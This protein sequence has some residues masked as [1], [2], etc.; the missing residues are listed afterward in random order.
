VFCGGPLAQLRV[1]LPV[2]AQVQRDIQ[3]AGRL[4]DLGLDGL[5]LLLRDLIE[6]SFMASPSCGSLGG[7]VFFC[8]S[9]WPGIPLD[10]AQQLGPSPFLVRGL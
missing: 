3:S 1:Q 7:R 5:G 8:L 6:D 2:N 4:G 9:R 10:P